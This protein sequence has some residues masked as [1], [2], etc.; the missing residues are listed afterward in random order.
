MVIS[1]FLRC[2]L[3]FFCGSKKEKSVFICR[4]TNYA[5]ICGPPF[6]L[7]TKNRPKRRRKKKSSSSCFFFS[8][9][10]LQCCL[11]SALSNHLAHLE[12]A[13]TLNDTAGQTRAYLNLANCLERLQELPKALYFLSL[14]WK[15]TE[16][17]SFVSSSIY[18]PLHNM[19]PSPFFMDN[20]TTFTARFPKCSLKGNL[21]T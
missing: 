13:R 10:R 9:S 3:F 11:F 5:K 18:L 12:L 2:K 19:P 7:N 8:K 21:R 16:S 15:L 6:F 17:V 14:Y 4:I 20:M 1:G